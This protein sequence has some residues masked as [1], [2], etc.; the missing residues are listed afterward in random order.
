MNTYFFML[1]FSSSENNGSLF[2]FHSN[3]TSHIHSMLYDF[4]ARSAQGVSLDQSS[5]LESCVIESLLCFTVSS[6]PKSMEHTKFDPFTIRRQRENG[7][8][9]PVTVRAVSIFICCFDEGCFRSVGL[10]SF[11][12][13]AFVLLSRLLFR[14]LVVS[15]LCCVCSKSV[16]KPWLLDE[17]SV[18]GLV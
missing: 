16:S 12:R 6:S 4:F 2:C 5:P 8:F 14:S 15:F 3:P 11:C 9:S 7:C 10:L 1:P 17:T 18:S 13:V